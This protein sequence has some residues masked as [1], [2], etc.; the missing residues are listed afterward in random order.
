[1]LGPRYKKKTEKLNFFSSTHL[2]SQPGS[3]RAPVF[4]LLLLLLL[5]IYFLLN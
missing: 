4:V 2:L 1:M 5:A 3:H